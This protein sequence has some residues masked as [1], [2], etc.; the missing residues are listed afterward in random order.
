SISYVGGTGNDVVLTVT[1]GIRTWTGTTSN[2]WN[3]AGNWQ[4]NSV[5]AATMDLVFPSGAANLSN[6]NNITAG[7][8]FNSITITG[9]GYTLAGNSIAL[10][11]GN[12]TDTNTSGSNTIS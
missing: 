2:L 1:G 9:S 8:S 4:E 7:T 12:L 11:A 6:S 5:P 3:V 10:A